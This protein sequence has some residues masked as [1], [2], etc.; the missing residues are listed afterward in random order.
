M[1]EFKTEMKAKKKKPTKSNQTILYSNSFTL[2]KEQ[3]AERGP[4]S[5]RV[6]R[7]REVL[8]LVLPVPSFGISSK[9]WGCSY[10]V[11]KMEDT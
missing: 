9:A 10:H 11:Y 7:G 4:A 5:R 3:C 2:G 6:A 8:M 1:N